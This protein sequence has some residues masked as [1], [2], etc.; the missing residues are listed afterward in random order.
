MFESWRTE[1]SR[2]PLEP[3]T[4]SNGMSDITAASVSTY[5]PVSRSIMDSQ[6]DSRI[7]V[8]LEEGEF[9]RASSPNE[10]HSTHL[11]EPSEMAEATAKDPGSN[12]EKDQASPKINPKQPRSL[13][14][15]SEMAAATGTHLISI[16]EK[17]KGK[18]PGPSKRKRCQCRLVNMDRLAHS[19]FVVEVPGE[20]NER[21][22]KS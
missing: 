8:V 10:I 15:L 5:D 7:P 13:M 19:F 12:H 3:P 14:K 22:K 9:V 17:N 16:T 21:K 6:A 18:G 2:R 20:E 11:G 1:I 4:P